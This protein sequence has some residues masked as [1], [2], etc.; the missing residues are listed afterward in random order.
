MKKKKE[1]YDNTSIKTLK[2]PECVQKRPS[3]YIGELGT[4]GLGTLLRE[5]YD[6]AIDEAING[7]GNEISIFIDKGQYTV[8]DHGRG[9]PVENNILID[10]LCTLHTGGKFDEDSYSSSAGTNGIGI[11]AINALSDET[12]LISKRDGYEFKQIFS[13]GKPKTKLTK[14]KKTNK[15]GT[16]ISFKPNIKLMQLE[17]TDIKNWF[18]FNVLKDTVKF[19][20]YLNK[21]LKFNLINKITNEKV[22][23]YFKNGIKDFIKDYNKNSIIKN[24]FYFNELDP[25]TK[26]NV[27]I[28]LGY[29]SSSDENTK[30]YCNGIY[31]SEGGTH[32][33]GFRMSLTGIMNS[34]LKNSNLLTK[35]DSNLEFTGEDFREGLLAIISIKHPNP[36]YVGQTKQRLTNRDAQSAVQKLM[37]KNFLDFLNNNVEDAKNICKKA[38][39][40]AKGRKAAQ[41]AKDLF[42]SKAT[43][44]NAF[45]SISDL[46]KFSSCISKDPKNCEL[47]ILEGDSAGS[48]A[49]QGRDVNTQAIYCLKGKPLNTNDIKDSTIFLSQKS[50]KYNKEL[51]D[52]VIIL[53]CGYKDSFDETKLK[54]NKV[55]IASDADIDGF[56]IQSLMLTFFYNHMSGLIKTGHVY[57]ALS[58]LY[59]IIENGKPKYLLDDFVY[60]D[61]IN[62]NIYE[63]NKINLN[64]KKLS[65][66]EFFKFADI[67]RKYIKL[68]DP[69]SKEF[70]LDYN[71]LEIILEALEKNNKKL[72]ATKKYLISKKC[73]PELK[74]I[75]DK[76]N[77][78]LEI[79]GF[80]NQDYINFYI[81]KTFFKSIRNVLDFRKENSDKMIINFNGEDFYSGYIIDTKIKENSPK[82]RQRLKGLGEQ[83]YMD[84][85]ETT[86]NKE[87][88]TLL[89]V[90]MEDFEKSGETIDML[91]NKA[92]YEERRKF[93]ESKSARLE[94]LDIS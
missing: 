10:L 87:T 23:Y 2:Y 53:G 89:K 40:A 82:Y 59:K 86:M 65:K 55:I 8:E 4:V 25:K 20:A 27:E 19:L 5:A 71:S 75:Y 6:N 15:T 62:N 14:I 67:M 45:S 77:H 11:K 78:S 70:G 56:D 66:K 18:D 69:L 47:F 83:D 49:R 68:I 51:S 34:F 84:L 26:I 91:F 44:G 24:I 76:E 42:L 52:L 3:M 80:I 46:K 9:M 43:E 57:I 61:Y 12:I 72:I 21:G 48:G 38:I 32:L 33:Q 30:C 94:D 58:P 1:V 85:F 22:S 29:N 60:N 50:K 73:F 63:N 90:E 81:D 79:S 16:I 39:M 93:L 88:R 64:N 28:A 35:K 7:Y 36:L 92:R 31:S 37:N 41:R 13:L 54:Y 17:N 74:Y